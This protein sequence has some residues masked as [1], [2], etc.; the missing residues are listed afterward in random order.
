VAF[1]LPEQI[2]HGEPD[3][4]PQAELLF[5]GAVIFRRY[6]LRMNSVWSVRTVLLHH[7]CGHDPDVVSHQLDIGAPTLPSM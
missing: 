3:L 5:S 2:Q 4:K 6:E 1:S 7:I